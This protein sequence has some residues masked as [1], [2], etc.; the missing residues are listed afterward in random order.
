MESTGAKN[1]EKS[2]RGLISLKT[3]RNIIKLRGKGRVDFK[4]SAK[5]I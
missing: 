1:E 4:V 5:G 2:K 3:K